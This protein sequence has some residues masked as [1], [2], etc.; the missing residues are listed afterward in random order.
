MYLVDLSFLGY[1]TTLTYEE[2]L[3][4]LPSFS[5]VAYTLKRKEASPSETSVTIYRLT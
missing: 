5:V 1:D 2:L 4:L 3:S